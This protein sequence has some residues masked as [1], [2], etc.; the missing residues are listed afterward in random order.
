MSRLKR[1][2][3]PHLMLELDTDKEI[4]DHISRELGRLSLDKNAMVY[5]GIDATGLEKLTE[6][7]ARESTFACTFED[8]LLQADSYDKYRDKDTFYPLT[9]VREAN[10]PGLIAY[11]ANLLESFEQKEVPAL[12]LPKMGTSVSVAARALILFR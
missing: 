10:T 5:C 9:Y 8:L 12:W 6:L 11:E 1:I 7:P 4:I 2:V 3:V